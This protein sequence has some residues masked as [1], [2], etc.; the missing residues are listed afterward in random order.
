MASTRFWLS[1]TQQALLHLEHRGGDAVTVGSGLAHQREQRRA[2][3]IDL[4]DHA[5]EIELEAGVELAGQLLHAPVLGEAIHAQQLHAAIARGQQRALQQFGPDA[6]ALPGLLDAEGGFRSA[7]KR[8]AALSQLSGA[9]QH[10]IDEEN[11]H[12]HVEAVAS[13]G[14]VGDEIVRH[15]A[16]K[17]PVAAVAVEPQ[18]MVAII[19]VSPTHN[20]RMAPS[21]GKS[22]C[23]GWF[24][25]S[26]PVIWCNATK[27]WSNSFRHTEPLKLHS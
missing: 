19:S 18:Q 22:S 4:A 24:L 9:A 17:P 2:W 20:L 8:R 21:S 26:V 14:T 7:D 1:H 16:G 3:R 15:R 27:K 13:R 5:A 25:M 10:P 11:V 12:D 6:E 23:I